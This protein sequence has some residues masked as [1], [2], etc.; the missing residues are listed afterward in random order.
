MGVV[1][2]KVLIIDDDAALC[3]A[4]STA[5]SDEGYAVVAA[6]NGLEGLRYL[7]TTD[8]MPCVILLD[9]MMPVMDAFQF[10]EEQQNDPALAAV[11][12]V[13]LTAGGTTPRLSQIGAAICVHKP[14]DLNVLL[15]IVAQY[16]SA[17]PT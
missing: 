2:E 7:R 1:Y 15:S 8:E 10:L 11:P 17:A 3:D 5:L 9:V 13:V 6:E 16:C 12:V 14:V 4:L